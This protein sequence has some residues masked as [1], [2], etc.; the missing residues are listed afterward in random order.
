MKIKVCGMRQQGNIEELVALQPN[1]IGFI[2]YEKSPRFVGEELNEEYIRSIPGNI[3]KVG[4]FVNASPGFILS[5]VKKYDLQYAQLH[6]NEM[7]DICRSIR[8]KGVNVIKAFS[9]DEKFNFAMLNNYK[10]FCDLF[11]FDTKGANPGGNG[12]SFDWNLLKKYD[13]EK[14]FFLSGGISIENVEEIIALSKTLPIYGIDV[15]SQFET[16]PGVKDISK[17]E[18]LF[19][20]VR[21]KEQ[22]EAEA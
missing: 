1:F 14:P 20:L 9:I 12:T 22:E 10:S 15:N 17:L 2:F 5:T 16:E 21:V 13:N 8:Q 18:E 19:N 4:V 11:L 7:P 6:G 3:K